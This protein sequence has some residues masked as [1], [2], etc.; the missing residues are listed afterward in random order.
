MIIDIS[1]I[2]PAMAFILYVFFAI[3]GFT[4]YRKE[5]F[6]WSFQ[7]YVMAIAIWSFGSFMMHLNSHILTPLAWNKIMLVGLLA[8]PFTLIHSVVNIMGLHNRSYTIFIVLSYLLF[9][10][11]MYFNFSGTIVT[12]VGFTQDNVFYY[13]LGDGAIGAYSI[14]YVFLIFSLGI[15]IYESKLNSSAVIRKNL[16]LPLLGT[17]I[18]LIGILFN[19]IPA[20]GI[21]PVDVLSAGINAG[22]LFYTIYRYKLV[23]Y[24]RV[25][26]RIMLVVILSVAASVIFYLILLFIRVLRPSFAPYDILPLS[27]LLGV[28]TALITSPLRSVMAYII[29]TVIIP[30]RHPYQAAI[31]KL[32]QKLT[33]VIEL[34][35]LGDEVVSSLSSG[36]K[37]EWA[38]FLVQDIKDDKNGFILL[39]NNNCSTKTKLGETVELDFTRVL[40]NEVEL[41]RSRDI[42]SLIYS[43][44]REEAYDVSPQLP[45]ADIIIPLVYR[46]QISGY[47]ISSFP[48]YKSMISKY[49]IEALEILAAQ[50]S[51]SLKNALSFEHIKAQGDELYLSNSKLEAI[52]NGIALPVAMTNVDF[53]IIEINNAATMFFGKPR[54]KLIGQKCYRAF[55]GRNRPC[56]Y[57]KSLDCIHG[58]G[59]IEIEAEVKNSI[60][61]FQF[62]NVRVPQN[63][64][65]VFVEIIRDVTEQKRLQEDLIRTEKMAGIGTLAAGIAHEL[66]NPLAGIAGT[67]EIILSELDEGSSLKEYADDILSYAMNAADVIK[68][69]SVYTRKEEKELQEVDIVR[70]LE[71]SLRLAT[72]GIDSQ[73]IH[74][75]RN[76]HALPHIKAHESDLQQLFLNLIV[77]AIQAMDGKGDLTLICYE[78][79]GS[80][81]ITVEDTGCGIPPEDMNQIFTPFFT[82]KP[83]GT[84]TGLG[85]SNCFNLVEKMYGRL[86][87]RSTVG[88]GS[89]FSAIF[90]VNEEGKTAIRFSLVRDDE[91]ALNDIF[92]LQRKVLIGEKGYIEESI[93]R[94]FDEDA[95]HILAYRG[96]HPVGTVSLLTS[97]KIWPLPVG[98]N[99]DITELIPKKGSG[100]IIRLAVLPEA[101]NSAVSIGLI[102]LVYLLARSVGVDNLVIDVFRDDEKTINLYRKFG[103][104]EV[105]EYFSPAAV[106]VLLLRGKSS[107]EKDEKRLRS[108]IK[109]LYKKLI[110]MFDFGDFH[111]RKVIQQMEEIVHQK[112][113][114]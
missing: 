106:T 76:Y 65:M 4:Q 37:A 70:V 6:Y 113:S 27:I 72:R 96:I 77:N 53:T 102:M 41:S 88:I 11:L 71:F 68:E 17:V 95:M 21:Y 19:L 99:F 3:F 43:V 97:D 14:S 1:T 28:T 110:P 67:A 64:K 13:K 75:R 36:L 87:V 5:R 15:M 22:L 59:M 44:H 39:S 79:S 80:V 35:E 100:E 55:F 18:M 58:G 89:A 8:V 48:E 30:K 24:S 20:L 45:P 93:Q 66:N 81:Y 103:F 90:P 40:Q 57:C 16:R 42:S 62:N 98:E 23:N 32:S 52:F 60:Y 54:E 109:P 7:V 74:V 82:T 92:Y 31:S 84:G 50:C 78:D 91:T 101:R 34:N 25:A 56:S 108:F 38:V 33:T 49:E 107:M 47:I 61:L 26:L 83:P 104:I 112:L 10:P 86:R 51:L 105:G 114:D 46:K 29:D 2:I 111:N 73:G 94:T 63:Q 85:L 69:L 12:D 9:I